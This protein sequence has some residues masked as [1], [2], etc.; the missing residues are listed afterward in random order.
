MKKPFRVA[1]FESVADADRAIGALIE[2]GFAKD[3]ISVICPQCAAPIRPG[4][5]EEQPAGAHTGE[6][7][8]VGGAIGAVLGGVTAAIGIA[9]SGGT[10]LLV[11]GPLLSG[12]YGA[13]AGAVG[14]GF[15]GA[16][17][18]RGFEREIA[19]YYDQALEKNQVLVAVEADDERRLAQAEHVLSDVGAVPISLPAG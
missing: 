11:A 19:D 1:V 8:A 2:A 10:A 6:S 16:M 15:V 17:M 3:A 5:H 13:A 14:G 7:A 4:L 9:A 18:S 12:L